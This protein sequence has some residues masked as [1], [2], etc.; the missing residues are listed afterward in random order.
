MFFQFYYENVPLYYSWRS[1]L[2]PAGTPYATMTILPENSTAD[3]ILFIEGVTTVPPYRLVAYNDD[4]DNVAQATYQLA[5]KDA[6]LCRT[7]LTSAR[8]L[9]VI[10]Y[11]SYNPETTCTVLARVPEMGDAISSEL[12]NLLSRRETTTDITTTKLAD[13]PMLPKD[14]YDLS[15]RSLKGVPQ[16]GVYI[17]G[18]RKYIV[19]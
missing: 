19:R 12:A 8:G 2:Q 3:P 13:T 15:G 5:P 18:G 7:Y 14:I 1:V 11:A 9:R 4:A 10:N 6:Y 16:K 17:K